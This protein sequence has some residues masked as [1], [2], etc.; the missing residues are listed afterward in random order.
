MFNP[1]VFVVIALVLC[2]PAQAEESV[3]DASARIHLAAAKA[4]GNLV[5]DAYL[6]RAMDFALHVSESTDKQ[7]PVLRAELAQERDRL[8]Q[9]V[10]EGFEREPVLLATLGNCLGRRDDASDYTACRQQLAARAKDNGYHHLLLMGFAGESGDEEAVKHH[11]R[12]ML[13]APDFDPD[14]IVVFASLFD[15]YRQVPHALWDLAGNEDGPAASAGIQAMAVSAAIALPAYQKL[16]R[17][18][19]STD[20]QV[21]ALC[22]DVAQH[23]VTRSPLMLDHMV[24]MALLKKVGDPADLDQVRSIERE[25]RWLQLSLIDFDQELDDSQKEQYFELF[26]EDGE[27]AAMRFASK[28]TGRSP[29]PPADWQP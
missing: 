1:K 8:N 4:P 21:R 2:L 9:R 20:A 19:D 24:A 11:A 7:D 25:L 22:G 28:A 14:M 27:F 23:V 10:L 12:K 3:A 5:S 16:Y 17:T 26:A 18:C 6:V 13:E 29:L 15:R